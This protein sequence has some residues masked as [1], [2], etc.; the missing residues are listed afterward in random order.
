MLT[1]AGVIPIQYTNGSI[2]ITTRSRNTALELVD[3]RNIMA[4]EPMSRDDALPLFEKKLARHDAANDATELPALSLCCLP[5]FRQPHTSPKDCHA[6]PCN[7]TFGAFDTS[8]SRVS[9]GFEDDVLALRNYSFISI[10][11]NGNKPRNARTGTASH[12]EMA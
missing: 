8:L 11:A 6:T 4:I 3:Q 7:S 10:N 2:L 5:L 12:L 1:A 9:D